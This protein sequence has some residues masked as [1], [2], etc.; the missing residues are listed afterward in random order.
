V[1]QNLTKKLNIG[2]PE[3]WRPIEVLDPKN[4]CLSLSPLKRI[5]GNGEILI[6]FAADGSARA[7]SAVCPHRKFPLAEFGRRGRTSGT[8]LCGAHQLEF[9][10]TTGNC[11]AGTDC[12][13]CVPALGSW[14]VLAQPDGSYAIEMNTEEAQ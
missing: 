13:E 5:P 7:I 1:T 9:D 3:D 6:A 2:K 10:V 14:P 8:I 12:Q 4:L 11:I